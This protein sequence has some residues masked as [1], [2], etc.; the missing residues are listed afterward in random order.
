[1]AR[2]EVVLPAAL[3]APAAPG[4]LPCEAAT[5]RELLQVVAQ[6]RPAVE[7]RLLFDGRPLVSVVRTGVSLAPPA[8]LATEL[9]DGDEVELLPPVAGG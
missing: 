2:V 3:T 5:V 9:A 1:M 7:P 4:R 8:A 6:A